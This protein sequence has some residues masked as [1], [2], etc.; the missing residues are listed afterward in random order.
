MGVPFLNQRIRVCVH[1]VLYNLHLVLVPFFGRHTAQNYVKLIKVLLD[2]LS[3]IWRDR[4][5]S[6]SS[7]GEN[8]MTGRYGG[9]VTLLEQECLNP[10]LRIMVCPAPAENWGQERN[11]WC[12]R[13]VVP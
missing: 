3:P 2:S 5:I 13:R 9:V 1:G 12:V 11:A 4:V 7:D 8:T 10:V 6:I